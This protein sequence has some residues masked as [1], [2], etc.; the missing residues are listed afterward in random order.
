MVDVGPTIWADQIV[1]HQ[2]VVHVVFVSWDW[3]FPRP[4]G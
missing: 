4:T 2:D 1:F 3:G